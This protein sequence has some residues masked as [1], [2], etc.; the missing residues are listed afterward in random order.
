MSA[1]IVTQIQSLGVRLGDNL[2]PRKGGAGPADA[3]TFLIDGRA[4]SV[5]T[6]SPYVSASPYSLRAGEESFFLCKDGRLDLLPVE[7]ISRP[8]F[9]GQAAG[10]GTPCSK[11]ALLHG[12]DCLATSVL[13]TCVYWKSERRC[14][15]CGIELSLKNGQTIAL[16]SPSQLAD[17]ASSAMALDGVKHVVL[18]TGAARPRDAEFTILAEASS[19]IKKATGLPIHAQFLPPV[20]LEKL[21]DLKR[22]GVDTVGIHIESF[23]MQ[24]LSRIAPMKAAIGLRGYDEAWKAAVEIFGP[25]QVSSFLIA[26]LGERPETIGSGCEYLADLGVYPFLVPLRPIPGSLLENVVPPDP[27]IMI[28]HYEKAAAILEQAGLS[29]SRSL[30][31][32]VRCGACSALPLYERAEP[33]LT[34]HRARTSFE[35][36][37]AFE[38]RKQ[39]FVD[40]QE[41]FAGSDTDANDSHSI[42]L[43]V[44]HGQELVGTVRVFCNGD[45]NEHWI[46]GR[47]AVKK[48]YRAF[49]A[50]ELLVRKAVAT[51][52]KQGCTRFT[53]FIQER[54]V[55]FFLRLGWK[56]VGNPKLHFGRVHQ[57][58]EA[59]LEDR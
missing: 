48:G 33:A 4:V 24:T 44:K 38:I 15:F 12:K 1:H 20:D 17:T 13:Q 18:T 25:N 7:L 43:V 37:Q 32:C 30:A 29:A 34:C 5:P 16:K 11:I 58:M 39:V 54:N 23:D 9:Y 51:I 55:P 50:G 19:A 52:K 2:L 42:H 26:G 41:M 56:T 59:D 47:L 14:R 57:I 36:S 10:D 31:G 28:G 49:G 22:S 35:L 21:R 45:G 3:G 46:G 6:V 40:E 8:R 27:S 53:A